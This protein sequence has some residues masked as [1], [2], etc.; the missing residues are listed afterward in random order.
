MAKR[1][2][3]RITPPERPASPQAP[4]PILTPGSPILDPEPLTPAWRPGETSPLTDF[5]LH[6]FNEGTHHKLYS[7][8]GCQLSRDPARPGAHF[9]V[10]APNAKTVNVM[11]VFNGWN[12]HAHPLTP[13]GSSGVWEGFIP[14][15]A[16]G[17]VYKYFVESLHGKYMSDRA[18]PFGFLH[19]VSPETASVAWDL[20]YAWSDAAWMRSRA[21]RAG[22]DKPMSIYE[23]HAGSWRR[24]TSERNRSLTYRELAHELADYC[25]EMGFTH[26]ELLP[27][28]EHPFFKSWG[29]QTL[30]YFAPTSRFGTPQDFMA[31]VDHLHQKGIGVIVDWVPS[32]FP[33][34]EHGLAYFDG[35]HLYEH[36]DP[37]QGY[38]PDWKSCIFNYGRNEVRAFLIS[39]AMFWMDKY[40]VDGLRVDAVASML[41]LDYSRKEGE[42]LPN[43]FG[44]K[45]NLDAIEFMRTLN[46]ALYREFEGIHTTAEESTA[47]SMVSAPVHVGGLGFGYK[48]DMGWMHDTLK[49][50]S[51]QPVHRKH[52]HN[53]ITFR[54]LYMFSENYVLPLSHDEVVHMKGSLLA[55]MPGDEWQKFANL[56]LLFANQWLHPGKK[57]LF[58]GG[59]IA[60]WAEFN[61][62]QQ[63]EWDLLRHPPHAG[64]QRFVKALNAL[65]LAEPALHATDCKPHG[66]RWVD[67]SDSA[68]SV[69]AFLRLPSVWDDPRDASQP[70]DDSSSANATA[71]P[72]APGLAVPAPPGTLLAVFNF[73]PVV[74]YEY[75]LGVPNPGRWAE[76]LNTDAAEYGGSG[77]G[78]LGGVQADAVAAHGFPQ[79]ISLTLPPL[80]AVVLRAP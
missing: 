52:H 23:V 4:G 21:S 67:C 75:R 69:I 59:E 44:G 51:R 16:R 77:V 48:W 41:Y 40:H 46:T 13:R 53:E 39:S 76:V 12:K 73:T 70:R 14:G 78:N 2:T 80:A 28:G 15:I 66:F 79:S 57:L 8:L 74:R 24:R 62:E 30:G 37:R 36:A 22:I 56:R 49:Y 20:D 34:D 63:C 65:Y 3:D 72:S 26:V 43:R 27:I 10:W 29:Y 54:G 35:T 5:D 11:G 31:C 68:Q 32:H 7:K 50:L 58:M 17:T 61:E 25:L 55:K 6:L 18:D 60:Q 42:W 33:S 38:H 9:A 47:W 45:E 19:Q 71:A 64:V 1:P